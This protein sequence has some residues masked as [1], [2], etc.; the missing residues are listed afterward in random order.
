MGPVVEVVFNGVPAGKDSKLGPNTTG[1]W[2]LV[3]KHLVACRFL[4][5]VS[6]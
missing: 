2:D 6:T 3:W 4:P 1:P 5:Q